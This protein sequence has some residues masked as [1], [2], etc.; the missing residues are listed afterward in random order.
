MG[1]ALS[2]SAAK[3]L[4]VRRLKIP[5]PGAVETQDAKLAGNTC[6]DV[7]QLCQDALLQSPAS[8]AFDWRW[9]AP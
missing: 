4:T 7:E 6:F 1:N 8:W 9:G 5:R 3:A 2:R